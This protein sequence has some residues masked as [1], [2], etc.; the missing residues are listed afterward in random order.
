MALH[1]FTTA[2]L[3]EHEAHLGK[4]AEGTAAAIWQLGSGSCVP[5]AVGRSIECQL[6]Y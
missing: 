6:V 4:A 5:S 3:I 1:G 2:R